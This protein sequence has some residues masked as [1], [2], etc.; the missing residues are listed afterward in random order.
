MVP[1]EERRALAALTALTEPGNRRLSDFVRRHGAIEALTAIRQNRFPGPDLA[2][3]QVRLG[4]LDPDRDLELAE[5]CGGR[6]V[7]P[8]DDEWP[9]QVDVLGEAGEIDQR[10]GPPLALW[11]RGPR[12]LADLDRRGCA[13][14]GARAASDYGVYVAAEL[15]AG[16]AERG[17]T[18]VSGAAFGIDAAA[19][20]GALAVRGPTIAV[21]ACGI[22]VA[23]PRAHQ[24][25]LEQIAD[26]GLVVSEVPPASTPNRPR[27]LVRNRLI[28]ALALGCVIVEAAV[29]SGALN[30]A[31]WAARC[32]REVM[33]V[34]GPVTSDRSA[35]V[36]R[37]IR[38]GGAVLVTEACEVA[39][40]IAPL[41]EDLV[42]LSR[43]ELRS[44]D[45]LAPRIRQV[46]EAV[47]VTRAVG[48]SRI[49]VVAGMPAQEVLSALGH[50][51]A[52]GYVEKSGSGW[53]LSADERDNRRH[54]TSMPGGP[55]DGAANGP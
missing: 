43:G 27:F 49:A 46:L 11:V 52:T 30:T 4:D 3:L 31:G 28:A 5:Q 45:V 50:L 44:R 2:D 38:D 37:L 14:V 32:Q 53:R 19:H 10:G 51:L 6:L 34:P 29:R 21:L 33:G 54:V 7:C 22:D 9:E 55:R 35:G 25:L 24:D 16:L 41:G 12:S 13:V 1:L 40:Q 42:P 8:G 18:V 48:A 15:G 39:E 20:R 17:I 23:Y 36:H 47:P 26:D